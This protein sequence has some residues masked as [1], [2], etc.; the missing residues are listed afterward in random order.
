MS[1]LAPAKCLDTVFLGNGASI[2]VSP[3]FWYRSLLEH[4]AEEQLLAADVQQ[5]FDSSARKTS[6]S[7]FG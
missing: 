5:I 3:T 6:S 2:S 7:L 4:A 1:L